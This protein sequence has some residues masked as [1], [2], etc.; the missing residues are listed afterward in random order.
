MQKFREEFSHSMAEVRSRLALLVGR[1]DEVGDQTAVLVQ[2]TDAVE[3]EVAEV[4]RQTSDLSEKLD[5]SL[6]ECE[7]RQ[8]EVEQQAVNLE[9]RT[10]LLE[11]H[12]P[13][14]VTRDMKKLVEQMEEM[15]E[16]LTLAESDAAKA[17]IASDDLQQHSQNMENKAQLTAND[18]KA[19]LERLISLER[20]FETSFPASDGK[21]LRSISSPS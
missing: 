12:S 19:L 2:R 15:E 9:V 1:A 10:T 6:S 17:K 20:R 16:R 5:C 8:E 3:R 13:A 7:K 4:Q 21:P 18:Q 14:A 11:S